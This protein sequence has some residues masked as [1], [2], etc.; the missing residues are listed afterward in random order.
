MRIVGGTVG[1]T[2]EIRRKLRVLAQGCL[3]GGLILANS[4]GGEILI[5]K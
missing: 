1:E 3:L 2:C 4:E 5:E